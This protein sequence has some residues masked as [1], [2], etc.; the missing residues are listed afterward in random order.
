VKKVQVNKITESPKGY[1]VYCGEG[2][3][4]TFT[5][6]REAKLFLGKLNRFLQMHVTLL[7]RK[8]IQ[9]FSL[10][11]EYFF[12]LHSDEKHTFSPKQ[13]FNIIDDAFNLAV[14]RSHWENGGVFTLHHIRVIYN[15]LETV[16]GQM[17][18]VAMLR[19][20]TPKIH[21][22]NAFKYEI[23]LIEKA[24]EEFQFEHDQPFSQTNSTLKVS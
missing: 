16:A 11:R 10:Y 7:N 3:T 20:D 22:L 2:L 13:S 17:L 6:K 18:Q 19:S 8:Y 4:F 15:S 9:V 23:R 24:F 14:G 21:E 1:S 5:S 12:I